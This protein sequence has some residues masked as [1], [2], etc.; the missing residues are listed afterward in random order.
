MK[1]LT[2]IAVAA[3][4]LVATPAFAGDAVYQFG[5]A[6]EISAWFYKTD[7]KRDLGNGVIEVWV[8]SFHNNDSTY[9]KVKALSVLRC[10]ERTYT[11]KTIVFYQDHKYVSQKEGKTNYVIPNSVYEGLFDTACGFTNQWSDVELMD[12]DRA[13]NVSMA[14]LSNS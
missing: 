2:T 10:N 4:A 6:S 13:Y 14:F 5:S 3:S 11:E 12:E 8:L 1:K 9:N 7:S